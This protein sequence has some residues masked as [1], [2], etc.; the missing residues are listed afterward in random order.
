MTVLRTVYDTAVDVI[1]YCF[2]WLKFLL[3]LKKILDLSMYVIYMK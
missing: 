2:V 3:E 1:L